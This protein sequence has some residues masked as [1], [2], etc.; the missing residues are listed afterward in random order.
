MYMY[1]CIYIVS[2]DI[3]YLYVHIFIAVD[4]TDNYIY[5][6]YINAI[7]IYIYI[8]YIDLAYIAC[9]CIYT[10]LDKLLNIYIN[11]KIGPYYTYYLHPFS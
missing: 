5:S 7:Y 6:T 2:C 11:L 10:N 9:T 1:N 4:I 8:P 3:Y